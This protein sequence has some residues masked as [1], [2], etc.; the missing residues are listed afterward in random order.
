MDGLDELLSFPTAI[1]Q[2]GGAIDGAFIVLKREDVDKK[3]TDKTINIHT[4]PIVMTDNTPSAVPEVAEI[5]AFI[6]STGVQPNYILAFNGEAVRKLLTNPNDKSRDINERLFM[7]KTGQSYSA[8]DQLVIKQV[9]FLCFFHHLFFLAKL[10]NYPSFPTFTDS[11]SDKFI[12]I[13]QKVGEQTKST[14]EIFGAPTADIVTFWEDLKKALSFDTKNTV[15]TMLELISKTPEEI[16]N[17]FIDQTIDAAAAA[18]PDASAA[19]PTAAAAAPT[20]SIA[21][22]PGAASMTTSQGFAAA[23]I[24][25]G[26]QGSKASAVAPKKL[27]PAGLVSPQAEASVEEKFAA[28][29]RPPPSAPSA[30]ITAAQ[31]AAATGRP[32]RKAAN[33]ARRLSAEVA[34]AAHPR[35]TAATLGHVA[36][37][38]NKEP[39]DK[40]RE[41]AGVLQQQEDAKK[42]AA[43][44]AAVTAV[45]TNAQ[46]AFNALPRNTPSIKEA[47]KEE[48]SNNNAP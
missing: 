10:A 43:R 14:E 34:A 2:D 48:N 23:S 25:S 5:S 33:A 24:T 32:T 22:V 6:G 17:Y 36:T 40:E 41:Q 27:V 13:Q 12:A 46:K 19:A 38:Q 26:S 11:F 42:A 18:A 45:A 20:G 16:Y 37:N 35:S 47:N 21:T 39:T 31:I 9:A 8:L 28:S 3:K 1:D 7:I 15:F 29:G 4:T 30:P 44:K